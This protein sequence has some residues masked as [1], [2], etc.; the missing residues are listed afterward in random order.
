MKHI[1]YL[2]SILIIFAGIN[3]SKSEES[4]TQ[5]DNITA[6]FRACETGNLDMLKEFI[7]IGIDV[8][9]KDQYGYS[10]LH[11]AVREEH[12]NIVEFLIENGAD[13]NAEDLA[14]NTPL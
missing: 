7:S 12:I 10:L 6:A 1:L 14:E 8:N 4:E 9:M 11:K 2:A 5:N 3:Y 13:V